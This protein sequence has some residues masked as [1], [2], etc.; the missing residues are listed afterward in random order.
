MNGAVVG[1]P[2]LRSIE[3]TSPARH[4]RSSPKLIFLTGRKILGKKVTQVGLKGEK[5][6]K[7]SAYS[8]RCTSV[9]AAFQQA[10]TKR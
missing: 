5:G 2:Y 7:T 10:A 4:L 8:N 6:E 9:S 3:S 1:H